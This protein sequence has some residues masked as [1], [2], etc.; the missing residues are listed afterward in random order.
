MKFATTIALF[1]V[2]AA[3]TV[4]AKP[5][6]TNAERMAR[7][8]PPLP[9]VRRRATGVQ[10]ARRS[11][12]SGISNSC[13][14]GPVQCCNTVTK[15]GTQAASYLLGLLGLGGIANDVLVGM[16]CSPLS[17]VGLGSNS[18]TQQPV[19]CENNHFNGLIVVGCSPINI[20][21]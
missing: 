5:A 7:G 15:A 18:C 6:H 12:P 20:N 19:C 8:L 16:Q 4:S 17:A 21:L 3:A 11:S 14:T 9:P 10:A 2:A 1:T 13:N